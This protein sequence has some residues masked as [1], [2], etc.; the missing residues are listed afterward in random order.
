VHGC[1]IFVF[2]VIKSQQELKEN[3]N[4]VELIFH[5]L[6]TVFPPQKLQNFIN[7]L[8]M[9][10]SEGE[11]SVLQNAGTQ[12]ATFLAGNEVLFLTRSC[13]SSKFLKLALHLIYQF[14]LY[15]SIL[16]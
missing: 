14:C 11:G 10:L 4:N 15:V 6:F 8:S 7:G 1:H 9:I 2:S 16:L 3:F 13:K 12:N 5:R